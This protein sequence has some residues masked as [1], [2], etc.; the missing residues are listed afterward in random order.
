MYRMCPSYFLERL[1]VGLMMDQQRERLAALNAPS[2]FVFIGTATLQDRQPCSC[3]GGDLPG[4][5]VERAIRQWAIANYAQTLEQL[6]ADHAEHHGI[7][8]F[9]GIGRPPVKDVLA[10]ILVNQRPAQF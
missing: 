9:P 6:A 10:V 3:F 5:I 4:V 2:P 8:Q 1:P 7:R